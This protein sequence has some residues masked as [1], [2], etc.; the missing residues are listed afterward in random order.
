MRNARPAPDPDTSFAAFAKGG[1][2]DDLARVFEATA[3]KLL[4]VALHL[5]RD[6]ADAEDLVQA[7]FVT[8]MEKAGDY[9]PARPLLPWLTGILQHHAKEARG[10]MRSPDPTRLDRPEPPVDPAQ[11]ARRREVDDALHAAID[12]LP[13][14]DRALLVLEVRHG[15]SPAEI[16]DVLGRAPGTVRVQLHRARERLRRVL[17][18]GVASMLALSATGLHAQGGAGRGLSAIGRELRALANARLEAATPVGVVVMQALLMKL[19]SKIGL[20]AAVLLLTGIAGGLALSSGGDRQDAPRVEA[21]AATNQARTSEGTAQ[22]ARAG[23]D[24]A[25]D[26]SE[27]NGA[28]RRTA[29]DDTERTSA[30]VVRLRVQRAH[31]AAPLAG[32]PL[33]IEPEDG[34]HPALHSATVVTDAHGF[35]ELQGLAAGAYRVVTDREVF[36]PDSDT[37]RLPFTLDNPQTF[38]SVVNRT[39]MFEGSYISVALGAASEPGVPVAHTIRLSSPDGDVSAAPGQITFG[40]FDVGLSDE[41]VSEEEARGM[42]EMLRTFELDERAGGSRAPELVATRFDLADEDIDVEIVLVGGVGVHGVVL[43]PDEQPAPGARL[44]ML[45]KDEK[46]TLPLRARADEAGRFAIPDL[47]AGARL[48]AFGVEGFAQGLPTALA[49]KD[50]DTVLHLGAPQGSLHGLVHTP[51]GTP[52]ADVRI[53]IGAVDG[54]TPPVR[55]RTD[56]EGHFGPIWTGLEELPV[57]VMATGFEPWMATV[58]SNPEEPT[59]LDVQLTP[60]WSLSGQVLNADGAPA[61]GVTV[62]AVAEDRPTTDVLAGPDGRFLLE[63]LPAGPVTLHVDGDGENWRDLDEPVQGFPGQEQSRDLERQPFGRIVVTVHDDRGEPLSGWVVRATPLH[64]SSKAPAVAGRVRDDG[65]ARLATWP[66]ETYRLEFQPDRA[67]RLMLSRS[68]GESIPLVFFAGPPQI[69]SG[70]RS[71]PGS[72]LGI[73]AVPGVVDKLDVL[74]P[75]HMLPNARLRGVL[76]DADGKPLRGTLRILLDEE[77]G[78]NVNLKEDGSFDTGQMLPGAYTFRLT[79]RGGQPFD[80]AVTALEPHQDLDVGTVSAPR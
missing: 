37:N 70:K 43:T 10:R 38:R 54:E 36:R 26:S 25:G 7:T 22:A 34:R 5:A 39:G 23:A 48:I 61:A 21:A 78:R 74:V 80:L 44:A 52:L 69:A 29:V 75:S 79:P 76:V 42:I 57:L 16:A 56:E 71:I 4:R 2:P 55:A 24:G 3:P 59:W 63:C 28:G 50:A 32:V 30:P 53:R 47:P 33:T 17:P 14:G 72:A 40:N 15:L 19:T 68:D 77:H 51:D 27:A 60:G 1:D 49:E 66:H 62:R 45:L 73:D 64:S 65:E 8:A 35:V 13:D 31:D 20:A 67:Q 18:A 12:R 46:E 9:D 6:T 58:R 11:A 41:T